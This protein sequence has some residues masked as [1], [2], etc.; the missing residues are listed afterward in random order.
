MGSSYKYRKTIFN[1]ELNKSKTIGA[2][3]L[4]DLK[5]KIEMQEKQWAEE[6]EKKRRVEAHRQDVIRKK[7]EALI[8]KQEK[9]KY[10]S[11]LER[12]ARLR[13]IEA[14]KTQE[15][16]DNL[17]KS[18][19]D[20]KPFDFNSLKIKKSFNIKCPKQ[21][22]LKELLVEPN[23]YDKRFYPEMDFWTRHSTKKLKEYKLKNDAEF[24][25]VHD[26]WEKNNNIITEY[27]TAVINKYKS[28]LEEWKLQKENFLKKQN[29][30]NA[31]VDMFK[32][33][34]EKGEAEAV[35][36][37]VNIILKRIKLPFESIISFD[38]EYYTENKSLAVNV[39]LPTK[40][41]IPNVKCVTYIKSKGE[42][43]ETYISETQVKRIYDNTIYKLVLLYLNYIFNINKITNLI[44]SVVLNGIVDTIDRTTG[45]EMCACILSVRV[46]R[47]DFEKLNLS[48]IDPKAWFRSSK[49][50]A[51][52]DITIVT[53]IQPIQKLNKEDKRFIEGYD[54]ISTVD[55]GVNLAA[56]DWQDFENLIREVFNEEFNVFG[57]EVK[58][59]QASRD[60]GVDAIAFDNDPIRGGK[61]VIQAKRYTNVV[62]VSAVRDLYG[63][64]INEGAMKGILVTTSYYG[65]D[66]Y[67][68]AKDK[69]IQLIDGAGLLGLMDRHGHK[70][71]IDLKEAK[72]ILNEK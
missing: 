54:V 71:R 24:K 72:K 58:I 34:V 62:G 20:L 7:E 42:F 53:P 16:I 29:N 2:Y 39:T 66:A 56:I 69:P 31:C 70:A 35:N 9:L 36:E 1:Q 65:N 26:D 55:E 22:V 44:E 13:T 60:G 64:V 19:T 41:D 68:F 38:T 25:K 10:E 28:D 59:T 49:G 18:N 67:E 8:E 12:S 40:E 63:T 32:K 3:S 61:I 52:A 27:N 11:S 17:L 45:N 43:K 23:R 57:G 14:E 48:E 30:Y 46:S 37:L 51:A 50:I 21:P 47:E 33:A 6:I 4:I 5:L 15:S